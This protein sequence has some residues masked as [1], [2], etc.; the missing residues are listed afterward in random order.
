MKKGK[1]LILLAYSDI[2]HHIWPTYNENQFRLKLSLKI[3]SNIWKIG[4]AKKIPILFNGDLIHKETEISNDLLDYLFSHYKGLNKIDCKVY[5]IS[6]NHDQAGISVIGKK[7]GSY[8]NTFSRLVKNL[9]CIDYKTI[10]IPNG[11]KTIAI[12]GIPYISHDLGLENY[13]REIVVP[14]LNKKKQ[15]ILMLHTTIPETMDT[16]GRVM[17][18]HS[19]GK[20]F[21]ELITENFDLIT[22]GHIHKPMVLNKNIIQVGAT[23]QQR[24]TDRDC[25]MG[26]WEIYSDLSFKFISI[27]SAKFIKLDSSEEAPDK[28]N[29]YYKENQTTRVDIESKNIVDRFSDSDDV[30]KISKSYLRAKGIKDKTKRLALVKALNKGKDDTI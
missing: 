6:G 28:L 16:D 12:H 19:L 8:I 13:I 25:D 29:Y 20:D 24:K 11:K 22:T 17:Q 3:E 30:E 23:N 7:V 14:K 9:K 18:T 10:E 5:A 27:K 26:Y 21:I 1:K 4:Q 15:N 2:H